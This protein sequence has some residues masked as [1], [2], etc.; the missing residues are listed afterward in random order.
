M[1]AGANV[2]ITKNTNDLTI[3]A[4]S[5]GETNTASN[6]GTGEGV[7]K[8]KTGSALEFKT[9][10]AGTGVTITNNT[11]D[12]TIDAESGSLDGLIT[13]NAVIGPISTGSDID[14]LSNPALA[15]GNYLIINPSNDIDL[16]GITAPAVGVN[17]VLFFTNS[18]NSKKVKFK[19][20]NS[21][22]SSDNRFLFKGDI[23]VE[24]NMGMILIYDHTA[25]KWRCL[26]KQN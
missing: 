12:L 3:D 2:T 11:S 7:F 9:L 17:Q 20:N 22:S 14:D 1:I 18:S 4:T 19:N 21:S 24:K 6:T 25:N 23:T 15:T 13:L 8:Q 5:S 10:V 16:T 26:T